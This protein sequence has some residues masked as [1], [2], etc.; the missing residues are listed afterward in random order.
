MK[1]ALEIENKN[2]YKT[3]VAK[4]GAIVAEGYSVTFCFVIL[5][6]ET[7]E[8]RVADAI[9]TNKGKVFDCFDKTASAHFGA[10]QLSLSAHVIDT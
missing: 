2:Q 6:T 7:A 9:T 3:S 1:L 10:R 8:V 4:K 5:T